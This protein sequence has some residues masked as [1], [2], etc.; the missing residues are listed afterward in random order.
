[1]KILFIR[2]NQ[3]AGRSIPIGISVLQACLKKAGHQVRIFDTTF[4]AENVNEQN[5]NVESLGFFKPT[6]MSRF[7]RE[8]GRGIEEEL[9][10]TLKDFKPD[11]A[12]FSVLTNDLA[13]A[14]RLTKIVKD[15]DNRITILF[16]GIHPTV[17]PE[18]TIGGDCVDMV[19]MGEGEEALVELLDR[20][21]AGKDIRSIS[22]FWI[23]QRDKVFRND[24]RPFLNMDTIPPPDCSGFNHMHLYKPFWG[25]VYRIIDVEVSRGCVC[26]CSECVNP[27]LQKIY[28][29]KCKYH[30]E[31]STGK[32]IA[33][34]KFIKEKYKVEMLRFVDEILFPRSIDK[35]KEFA[36]SYKQK[37]GLPFICFGRIGYL[38]EEK[39]SV[40]KD[41]GC[42][43]LS[44]GIESGN[45]H[46]RKNILNRPMTNEQ[47]V[48][49]FDVCN[50][51]RLRTM[52]FNLMSM[53]GEGRKEIFETIEV[54]RRSRPG[55]TCVGFVYPFPGTPLREFCLKKGYIKENDPIVDYERDSIIRNGKINKKKQIGL[56]RT[57]VL[58]AVCPKWLY[59]VI[60]LCEFDNP[61][62][63]WMRRLLVRFF[64]DINFNK[65]ELRFDEVPD[66]RVLSLSENPPCGLLE[67]DEIFR[68]K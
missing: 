25:R 50:R 62:S 63:N 29:G 27:T 53:P 31:K 66:K 67:E 46:I 37:I 13:L 20:M 44:I 68:T 41:M 18:A 14:M 54:N 17:A 22:N 32:A 61:V 7:T 35:L 39:V 11:L 47:I 2:P 38:T 55:L 48:E 5:Q 58:Y 60:R 49:A 15:V 23:K 34:L 42:V 4:L 8:K 21:S 6:D 28:K 57:F 16:G 12:A 26:A 56:F 36:A 9:I 51:H 33:D 64:R 65:N 43:S 3:I 10:K 24:V 52:A 30:R 1:M 45:E 19:C 40:L 59:P